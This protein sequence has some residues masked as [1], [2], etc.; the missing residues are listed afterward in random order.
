MKTGII[1][2]HYGINY[3]SALQSYALSRYMSRFEDN[4]VTVINYIP[5]RYTKTRRYLRTNNYISGIKKILYLLA[6]APNTFRY[7]IIFD[8]F[9]KN[10][11]PLGKKL[12]TISDLENIYGKYDLLISGSDQ[13][14]NTD[15]NEGVDPAYYLTFASKKTKKISYAASCGK[16]LFSREEL[17]ICKKY[18]SEFDY[19]SL[20]ED[21]TTKMFNDMG[22]ETAIQVLDPIFLLSETEWMQIL[23]KRKIKEPYVFIYA[24]D[25]DTMKAIEI[26]KRIAK[27]KGLKIVMV[28]Y[29]HIWS[30]DSNCDYYLKARN[31][32]QFLSL[33]ANSDYVVTNSFHGI[34]FSLRFRKQFIPVPREKYNNRIESILRLTGLEKRQCLDSNNSK[35]ELINY[36]D[37][38]D[39]IINNM[40]KQSKAYLERVMAD[41]D[42]NGR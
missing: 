5:K 34:A 14:W 35:I 25:G 6:V 39:E 10:Y 17:T 31:P 37:G 28:S 7:Q 21:V 30:H 1:T 42:G 23:P 32:L 19:L 36:S 15:Y 41:G 16:D 40:E 11:L 12:Y 38:I 22:F 33:I 9:L 13:V 20:R 27:E 8:R 29:G 24:L 18:W 26:A 2:I 4:E 3:G